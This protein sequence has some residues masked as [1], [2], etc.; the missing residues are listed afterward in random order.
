MLRGQRIERKD[1]DKRA[2]TLGHFERLDRHPKQRIHVEDRVREW[3]RGGKG[4]GG[5]LIEIVME[6]EIERER[7]REKDCH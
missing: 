6:T 7:E 1:K 5:V 2:H 4:G 3:G